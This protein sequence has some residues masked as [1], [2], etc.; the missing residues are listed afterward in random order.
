M[1]PTA[2]PVPPRREFLRQ[3]AVIAPLLALGSSIRAGE[4]TSAAA[5]AEADAAKLDAH[6]KQGPL[7]PAPTP[8]QLEAHAKLMAIPDINMHGSEQIALLLYPGFTALDLVGPHY[9]FACLMGA[10]VH[11]VTTGADLSPVASDLGLAIAPTVTLADCPADLDVLFI[12]GGTHGTLAAARDPAVLAFVQDRAVRARYLASV[13]TGA[14]VYGAAGLLRGK[15]ATS[16]W[17]VRE[18]L[19]AFGATPVDERIVWDGNFVSGAGVTAGIDLGLALVERL[20]SRAYAEALML[21]AE[22]APA[23]PFPFVTP[24]T[25]NPAITDGLY[26]MCSPLRD[27]AVELGRTLKP[28]VS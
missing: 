10:K 1:H 2:S 22:Y 12:P 23:P 13:C 14:F 26:Q 28:P 5:P 18:S 16:H 4:A 8:A 20:R 27:G 24:Q 7:Q 9:F 19:P 21:Q 11:L 17:I 15:R 25:A 6:H 3:L